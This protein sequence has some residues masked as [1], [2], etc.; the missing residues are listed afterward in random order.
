MYIGGVYFYLIYLNTYLYNYCIMEIAEPF[1]T[2]WND[3]TAGLR[4]FS[5]CIYT[6]DLF[7]DSDFRLIIAD[8]NR[9]L[10]VY[11]GTYTV[12]EYNLAD[13]PCGVCTV[14]THKDSRTKLMAIACG[15]SILFFSRLVN[16][17]RFEPPSINPADEEINAWNAFKQNKDLGAFRDTIQKLQEKEV[18]ISSKT[19]KHLSMPEI[20]I[21]K[22]ASTD[23]STLRINPNFTYMTTIK[24]LSDVSTSPD[25]I[26]VSR[27]NNQIL[28]IECVNFKVINS[29]TIPSV[30]Y[31]IVTQGH[32]DIESR[33]FAACRDNNIYIIKNGNLINQKIE[34]EIFITDLCLTEKLLYVA[35][36]DNAVQA[37][38]FEG[39]QDIRIETKYSVHCICPFYSKTHNFIFDGI[40]IST[41]NNEILLYDN[42]KLLSTIKVKANILGMFLG[43]YSREDGTLI[44]TTVE[45]AVEARILSRRWKPNANN[46]EPDN[47]LV[48]PKKTK[49]FVEMMNREKEKYESI[50]NT[51]LGDLDLIKFEL[52]KG[53]KYTNNSEAINQATV[54]FEMEVEVLGLGPEFIMNVYLIS[55]EDN[56]R[57]NY[58]MFVDYDIDQFWFTRNFITLNVIIPQVKY[59]YKLN[60]KN[61][62]ESGVG[63][64]VKLCIVKDG[65]S[66]P[67]FVKNVQLPQNF[68]N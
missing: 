50:Y 15:N 46:A 33:I 45:G 24:K 44:T 21:E 39:Q 32:Y 12:Y 7:N 60:Y 4:A 14:K 41:S 53:F 66:S 62:S 67:C 47:Q 30:V 19:L 17:H 48:V 51:F 54:R 52:A 5:H 25:L 2:L 34:C 31:K 3:N 56:T 6:E 29:I 26:V 13:I 63:G 43:R 16:Y 55:Y 49:V 1:I 22:L 9:T 40:L 11:K 59:Q 58:V 10:R 42:S 38:S 8:I 28:V 36:V 64:F 18:N 23:L 65:D 35:L 61:K 57:L 20:N 37:Y 68:G 27:E